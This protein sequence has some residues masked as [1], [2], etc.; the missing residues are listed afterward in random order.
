VIDAPSEKKKAR[1][2]KRKNRKKAFQD[3]Y[4]IA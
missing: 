3:I 2:K 4:W 1:G